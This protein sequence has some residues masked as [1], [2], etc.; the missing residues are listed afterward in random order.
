MAEA[1]SKQT[2]EKSLPDLGKAGDLEKAAVGTKRKLDSPDT[3]GGAKKE[4]VS[5][6]YKLCMIN[7]NL[8]CPWPE[9]SVVVSQ[10][11]RPSVCQ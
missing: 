3:E 6:I 7:I 4:K 10:I 2:V 5:G 1:V 11:I 8:L 9:R